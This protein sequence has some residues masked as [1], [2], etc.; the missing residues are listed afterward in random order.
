MR[1]CSYH[2]VQI[3]QGCNNYN[4]IPKEYINRLLEWK[5]H[6]VLNPSLKTEPND[7]PNDNLSKLIA[8]M[9][10]LYHNNQCKV[11][12]KESVLFLGIKPLSESIPIQVINWLT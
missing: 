3:H 8:Q 7:L 5:T 12:I 2:R 11:N 10:L 4:I 1:A 9:L 6:N